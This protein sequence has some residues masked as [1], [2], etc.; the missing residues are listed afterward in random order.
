M[1]NFI[2][3]I[4]SLTF[5]TIFLSGCIHSNGFT[6]FYDGMTANDLYGDPNYIHIETPQVAILPN[7]PL[8]QVV[9]D[10]FIEGYGLIG[11][12][13]WEGPGDN[14]DKDALKQARDVGA[15]LVLWRADYSHTDQGAVPITTYNPGSTSTTYHS[16]TIFAGGTMGSF[17][18]T[19]TT[20]NPGSTSTSYV[21]FSVNRYDYTALFFIKFK[22]GILGLWLDEPGSA[23][24]R[25]FDTNSGG[26]VVAVRKDGR[27]Y[28]ANIFQ[29]DIIMSV[30]GIPYKYDQEFKDWKY[31]QENSIKIYRDGKI[32]EKKIFVEAY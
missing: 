12:S 30:N 3:L 11:Q 27:A 16:G 15:A 13:I 6:K 14:D 17:G 32:I 24:Q 19:S 7:K 22:S 8:E 28:K 9:K 5:C 18:G 2:K 20:Y 26:L 21:P 1:K 25:K 23:Y 29:G 10:M 31:N 4:I